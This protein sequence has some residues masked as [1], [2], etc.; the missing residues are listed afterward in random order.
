MEKQNN[1][2][3]GDVYEVL[4][5][6]YLEEKG[7]KII[8]HNFRCHVGEIDIIALYQEYIVFIEVKYRKNMNHGNPLEAVTTKKQKVISKC[9]SYY[10]LIH[11]KYQNIGVRFDV[12]GVHKGEIAPQ[13]THIENAFEYSE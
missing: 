2:K 13:L 10:L 11:P 3:I 7:Y 1:R 5:I 6:A 9:A 8:E 12:V 4:V